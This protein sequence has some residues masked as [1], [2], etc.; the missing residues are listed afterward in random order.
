MNAFTY[1]NDTNIRRFENLLETT[2]DEA[3]RRIIESLLA[4]E[5]AKAE[6]LA[7]EPAEK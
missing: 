7:S 1:A 3:E 4:E 6:L 5:K 2:V